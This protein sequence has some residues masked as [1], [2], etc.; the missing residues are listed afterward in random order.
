M[1]LAL[2][3][4]LALAI[5]DTAGRAPTPV[6]TLATPAEAA[7]STTELF[8]AEKAIADQLDR[9]AFPGAVLAI[10]R[11]SQVV[12]EHGFGRMDFALGSPAA[13]PERTMYDLA[14]LTKVVATTTAVMLLVE[15]GRMDVNAPVSRYLPEFRGG[16][17]DDVRIWNLLTHTSGLPAWADLWGTHD[18]AAVARAVR[19]PLQRAPG[20]RVE[21]TDIGYIV[22]WAAAERAAGEPLYR[23]LDRR[24]FGP[25]GMRATMFLPGTACARCA[26]TIR[27]SDGTNVSGW[28]HDPLARQIGGIAGNAGLFSTAHDLGRFAAMLAQEGELDGVRVLKTETVRRF[29]RRQ[30]GADE[31]AL[32][33][34]TPQR[35]GRGAAGERISS[36]AFG[37]TGFTGTSLW[38][39]PERG[40]W[41]VL[42]SNRTYAPKSPN[43]MQALRRNVND[44]VASAVDRV[45]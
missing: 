34:E 16:W 30:P 42:L 6:H 17:K 28:V 44:F 35:G 23:L 19:T 22:L 11:G 20:M 43:R 45:P 13:D 2:V 24:I 10:G 37:H 27:R 1:M 8:R 14:S 12:V 32:G 41:T 3:V 39:D 38:V 5:G 15:D 40:T 7:M 33:W 9:G 21:Y 31:R 26:P 36:G 29:A 4:P 25:L 18:A